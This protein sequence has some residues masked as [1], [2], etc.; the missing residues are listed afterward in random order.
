MNEKL[1]WATLIVPA[2]MVAN[3]VASMS[4]LTT[5]PLEDYYLDAEY[6]DIDNS[7]MII[8]ATTVEDSRAVIATIPKDLIYLVE[9]ETSDD[10]LRFDYKTVFS[11]RRKG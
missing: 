3:G 10:R 4:I 2:D 8:K 5:L 1:Y 7:S 6:L 11:R 9:M